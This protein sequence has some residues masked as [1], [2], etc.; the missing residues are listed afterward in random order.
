MI[1]A[2]RRAAIRFD[3]SLMEKFKM[4]GCV[5]LRAVRQ[6]Q[7][8]FTARRV[9]TS[10]RLTVGLTLLLASPLAARA[11]FVF[12]TNPDGSL[13]VVGFSQSGPPGPLT[14]DMV[15]PD[16]TNGLPVTSIGQMAFK[17]TRI[18]TV[19]IGTNV[20]SIGDT[21]FEFCNSLTNITIG[22]Q[23]DEH[24]QLGLQWL[25]K[26]KP[27]KPKHQSHEYWGYGVLSLQES[28]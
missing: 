17:W 16:T 8:Q 19:Q 4:T 24:R 5:P 7:N 2:V 18:S 25:H 1:S 20:I 28:P 11:G 9:F 13:N 10:I 22:R 23:C 26:L 14:G 6:K 15:I 27:A 12:N 21:A 3:I